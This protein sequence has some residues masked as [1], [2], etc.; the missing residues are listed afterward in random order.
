MR[1]TLWAEQ[2]IRHKNE[3][4]I[5]AE[6]Y[7]HVHIIPNENDELLYKKY[8]NTNKPLRES[9]LGNLVDEDK[10]VIISPMDFIRNIDNNKYRDLL[11]YLQDRYWSG[12]VEYIRKRYWKNENIEHNEFTDRYIINDAGCFEE[13][14]NFS[15]IG[16][17][18]QKLWDKVSEGYTSHGGSMGLFAPKILGNEREIVYIIDYAFLRNA[19]VYAVFFDKKTNKIT[20]KMPYEIFLSIYDSLLESGYSEVGTQYWRNIFG[21]Q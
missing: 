6:D 8:K 12:K 18:G 20:R 21:K 7:I 4:R 10:Y 5:K 1:Q 2:M 19:T 17:D 14:D 11:K 3:E 16:M 9:W 15:G 13:F